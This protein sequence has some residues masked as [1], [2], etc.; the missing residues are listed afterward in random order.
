[1]NSFALT[2]AR[3]YYAL[4]RENDH[5]PTFGHGFDLHISS[6]AMS[7]NQSSTVGH[8]YN[9]EGHELN[10]GE[11]YFQVKDYVVLRAVSV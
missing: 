5:G 2:G 3:T 10:N 9:L 4:Y 1:M 6:G 11:R 8:T 7:N